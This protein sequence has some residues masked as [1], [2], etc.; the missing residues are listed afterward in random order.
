M[1]YYTG[2]IIENNYEELRSKKSNRQYFEEF[3]D[4]LYKNNIKYEPFEDSRAQ[5]LI[6]GNNGTEK[7]F[8]LYLVGGTNWWGISERSIL[9]FR[10]KSM[11]DSL[12]VAFY[13]NVDVPHYWVFKV[14]EIIP[15]TDG[16]YLFSEV[17]GSFTMPKDFITE[18]KYKSSEKIVP[19][20]Q[21]L[22]K[23]I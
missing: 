3:K 14:P 6:I 13:A 10:E 9:K 5:I 20:L 23:G 17:N 2:G 7:R 18:A 16:R 11:C 8:G 19:Y 15:D 1:D 4:I 22:L 12:Y 21:E